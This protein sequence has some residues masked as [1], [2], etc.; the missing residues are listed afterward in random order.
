MLAMTM[1]V[2]LVL[3]N[4]FGGRL[5]KS[6][7]DVAEFASTKLT[8]PK[9]QEGSLSADKLVLEVP[10]IHCGGCLET[11]KRHFTSEAGIKMG[12]RRRPNQTDLRNLPARHGNSRSHQDSNRAYWIPSCWLI[13]FVV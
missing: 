2:S 6:R 12:A 11:I 4:S 10:A 3:A 13:M 5:V 1:S 8:P 7:T 9:A